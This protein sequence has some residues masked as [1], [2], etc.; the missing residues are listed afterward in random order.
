MCKG[1]YLLLTRQSYYMHG[2][3]GSTEH[4]IQ[5][6]GLVLWA[7]AVK[8]AVNSAVRSCCEKHLLYN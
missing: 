7:K 8:I 5:E 4:K 3:G 6:V 1:M 2:C